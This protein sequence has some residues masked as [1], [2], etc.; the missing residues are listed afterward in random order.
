[1]VYSRHAWVSYGLWFRHG[2]LSRR[3]LRSLADV[4]YHHMESIGTKGYT[5]REARRIFSSRGIE[6]LRIAKVVTPYDI[7]YAG[8]LARISGP[9]LGFFMVIQG[10]KQFDGRAVHAAEESLVVSYPYPPMASVGGNRWLAM[11]KYLRRAGY[12]VEILTTSAFGSLPD[13]PELQVH[14]AFD[15]VGAHWL[16]KSLRRP[17]LP[18]AGAAAVD[19]T[20]PPAIVTKLVV[21]DHCAVCWVP[22]AVA[23][24]RRVLAAHSFDCIVTTSAYESTHLIPLALGRRRPAWIADF[25]DGWTFHPWKPPY[26]TR[27]QHRLDAFLERARRP[28]RGANDMRGSAGR[29]GLR[30]RDSGSTPPWRPQRIRDPELAADCRS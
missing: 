8:G 24:A 3:P 18:A 30:T 16:R 28:N 13:D 26:P 21:P 15:L 1:M 10:A 2:P 22:F 9:Q 17:P 23:T 5:K 27:A 19:D 20:P 25:R 14:R 11:S 4:L 6:Q 29:R 7:E 12:E